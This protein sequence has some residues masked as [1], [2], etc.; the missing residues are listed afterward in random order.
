MGFRYLLSNR[1]D[2]SQKFHLLK[3]QTQFQ[4]I[5]INQNVVT[6]SAMQPTVQ[7]MFTVTVGVQTET[8][9]LSGHAACGDISQT[10]GAKLK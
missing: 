2:L 5:I 3:Q 9:E 4:Q 7:L 10:S 1:S 8:A 6:P